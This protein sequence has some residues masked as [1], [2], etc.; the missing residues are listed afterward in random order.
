MLEMGKNTYNIVY[1]KHLHFFLNIVKFFSTFAI[2]GT[3]Y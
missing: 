3:R 1:T 2:L